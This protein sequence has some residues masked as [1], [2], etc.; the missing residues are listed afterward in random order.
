MLSL[1]FYMSKIPGSFLLFFLVPLSRMAASSKRLF[2]A[3]LAFAREL[4]GLG[5]KDNDPFAGRVA[6][7]RNPDN[8]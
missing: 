2:I 5:V 7:F 8:R 3:A 6:H 4:L 1:L